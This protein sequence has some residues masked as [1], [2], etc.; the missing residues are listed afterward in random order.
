MEGRQR[1]CCAVKKEKW[2]GRGRGETRETGV[3]RRGKE[4]GE[5]LREW[6]PRKDYDLNGKQ[7]GI[8]TGV[9]KNGGAGKTVIMIRSVYREKDAKNGEIS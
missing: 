3:K 2:V 8:Q 7:R 1:D 5:I 4:A 9:G 6:G